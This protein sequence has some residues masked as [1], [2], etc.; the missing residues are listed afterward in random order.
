M[1][2]SVYPEEVST[3]SLDRHE[4]RTQ[5]P[6]L[7]TFLT[8]HQYIPSMIR[9]YKAG[10]FPIEQLVKFYSVRDFPKA[11]KDMEDGVTIKPVLI[12]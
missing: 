10:C 12:W 4:R 5:G 2:G 1:E 9:W 7:I 8:L 6:Q 11:V 3:S